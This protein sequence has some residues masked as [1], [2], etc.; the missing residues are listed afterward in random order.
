M[1]NL[2]QILYESPVISAE[3]QTVIYIS[4]VIQLGMV[5]LKVLKTETNNPI[6]PQTS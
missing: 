6:S 1:Y 2:N 5:V 3:Y 4:L